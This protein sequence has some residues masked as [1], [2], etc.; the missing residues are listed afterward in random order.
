MIKHQS[1]DHVLM[2]RPVA[3]GYNLETAEN[4]FYQHKP[5]IEDSEEIQQKALAEF[6]QFAGKLREH[7]ITVTVI[8]DKASDD[9]PDSIF[10]NNWIS[11][12][13]DGKVVIYPMFAVNRRLEKRQSVIDELVERN[14]LHISDQT[15]L[16]YLEGSDQFLEGTGSL[17]LDRLHDVVYASVSER[18]DREALGIWCDQM[19]YNSVV[20]HAKQDHNGQ[21]V[22]IY[23]TNVMMCL[24]TDF[25]VI[26]LDCIDNIVERNMVE[27]SLKNSGR[28]IITISEKQVS[29]FAGNMLELRN[30]DNRRFLAMSGSA[31][32]SLDESQRLRLKKYCTLIYSDL[33]TIERLGG[34]SA[35]CMLAE[36]FLPKA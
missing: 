1:T 7:E 19:E 8:E 24:G 5:K 29:M 2:I 10:P 30:A 28:E 22:P 17:I 9:T 20:F 3:F 16:G 6:D 21:R 13:H 32:R 14:N 18:M 11:T 31:F 35:R 25:A 34:G 36:I 23:H 15:D 26:C 12:H 27:E 4:N 33:D